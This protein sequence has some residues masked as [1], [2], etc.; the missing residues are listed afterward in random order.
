[1]G[2]I[3]VAVLRYRL[4]DLDRV[5]SRTITYSVV[6]VVVA[7]VYAIG[8]V[9]LPTLIVGG[10]SPVFVAASTLIAAAVF[11]PTRRRVMKWVDRRFNRSRYQAEL[12]I[13]QFSASLQV[14]H[15]AE[16]IVDGLVELVATTFQPA[17]TRVWVRS[18]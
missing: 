6:A 4:Y 7:V 2:S 8:A 13:D 3:A 5:I 14:R 15:H 1:M 9:W 18:E 12:V 10:Q 17:T 11:T 16:E